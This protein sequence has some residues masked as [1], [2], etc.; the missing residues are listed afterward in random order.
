MQPSK[1]GWKNLAKQTVNYKSSWFFL[2]PHTN[3]GIIFF[4]AN[5]ELSFDHSYFVK[6]KLLKNIQKI[7]CN[8]ANVSVRINLV[9]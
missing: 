2:Y 3:I 5:I 9:Y 8:N 4:V 7:G 6:Y 1:P